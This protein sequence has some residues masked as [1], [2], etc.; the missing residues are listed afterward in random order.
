MRTFFHF[1]AAHSWKVIVLIAG[2]A[3]LGA[4]A[5][6]SFSAPN[7]HAAG[8][9]NLEGYAWSSNIGWI[10][11][12]GN[13]SGAGG[14]NY[15]VSEARSGALSG[16]AWSSNIGWVSFNT[17]DLA[18]CPS[19]SCSAKV[20]PNGKVTGWARVLSAPAAG[21]N[22]GGWGGWIKL[23]DTSAPAYG[24]TQS[25][26]GVWSGYAWGGGTTTTGV[27]GWIQFSGTAPSG[28]PY[29]VHTVGGSCSGTPLPTATLTVNGP[30]N[31]TV[32]W[33]CTNNTSATLTKNGNPVTISGS[34]NGTVSAQGGNIFTLTCKNTSGQKSTSTKTV[35]ITSTFTPASQSIVKGSSATLSWT[36]NVSSCSINHGVGAVSSSG[37]KNVSPTV[38]TNYRLTCGSVSPKTAVV[39]VTT[40]AL[41]Q[42][43]GGTLQAIPSMVPEGKSIPIKFK[44]KISTGSGSGTIDLSTCSIKN[45]MN[46]LPVFHSNSSTPSPSDHSS[47]MSGHIPP[48]SFVERETQSTPITL[49]HQGRYEISCGGVSVPNATAIVNLVPQYGSF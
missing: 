18:G 40:L 37:T 36:S 45:R 20:L 47:R 21:S 13:N 49:S 31:K 4:V 42:I 14:G 34:S 24:V 6:Q 41:P 11:F 39:N 12:N 46:N 7:A 16:Y 17:S 22:A 32:T 27:I 23:S 3:F 10:S 35:S 30:T 25:N 8:S 1:P 33:K 15:A 38:T 43:S 5:L 29:C 28:T 48:N 19:G 26:N 2:F 9:T 44:W